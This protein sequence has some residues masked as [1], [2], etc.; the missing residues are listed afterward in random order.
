MTQN[1]ID[2]ALNLGTTD[3]AIVVV[4]GTSGGEL[5]ATGVEIDSNDYLINAVRIG[6][7]TAS[8]VN[9]LDVEGAAAIG[10]TYSGF[11]TAPTD[12]LI[13]EGDTAIG[14]PVTVDS[15]FY[16]YD[17]GLTPVNDSN[18]ASNQF[19]MILQGDGDVGDTVGMGFITNSSLSGT[20]I[21]TAAIVAEDT[22]ASNIADLVFFTRDGTG[23]AERMRIDSDGNVG[24]GILPLNKLDVV[25]NAAI[26]TNYAGI[27]AAPTDGMLIEGNVGI[28]EVSPTASLHVSGSAGDVLIDSD[29]TTPGDIATLA[30]ARAYNSVA[31]QARVA[32]LVA[33]CGVARTNIAGIYMDH[34]SGD[35]TGRIEF[36]TSL[37]GISSEKMRIDESGH[38][39][40]GTTNPQYLLHVDRTVSP[41]I[42]LSTDSNLSQN[43][44]NLNIGRF[45]ASLNNGD[46]LGN[47][48][49]FA[50][51]TPFNCARIRAEVTTN[52]ENE[53]R[54]EFSTANGSS[55]QTCLTIDEDQR[56]LINSSDSILN[57]SLVIEGESQFSVDVTSADDIV[58]G[59]LL[60]S[61]DTYVCASYGHVRIHA[62][63]NENS[64]DRQIIFQASTTEMGRINQSTSHWGVAGDFSI[65]APPNG[66]TVAQNASIGSGYA[67]DTAPSNGLIIEGQT[68]IG[69]NSPN[70][71]AILE[72]SS[73]S[74]GVRLP[75]MTTTQ[76]NGISSPAEGLLIYN[77][78]TN[79][80]NVYTTAWEEVTSS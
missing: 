38:V 72:I 54:L 14:R 49:F 29:S 63:I 73:T 74:Q 48:N 50:R 37:V 42:T 11:N 78:T 20:S 32:Q 45:S 47:I 77:T 65:T 4:E 24:I 3:D 9:T 71:S 1:A 80:L 46:A 34:V 36:W 10:S 6:A 68:A 52:A 51:T 18:N 56:V 43:T 69:T 28:G 2:L 58:A 25:G 8:P 12:G 64:G 16:V 23:N 7:N 19:Q 75:N 15:K 30:F 60:S 66:L 31:G 35:N 41:D 53:G 17:T 22:G 62:D 57:K 5:R 21:T 67:N 27:Q 39:G 26:G 70:A 33:T 76:R 40:I 79:K 44:P 55:L 61:A 13:V 59:N